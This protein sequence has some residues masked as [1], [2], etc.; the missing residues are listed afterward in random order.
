[1]LESKVIRFD[2]KASPYLFPMQKKTNLSCYLISAYVKL[3][4]Y[5]PAGCNALVF[6]MKVNRGKNV[7][8]LHTKYCL[9]KSVLE[10]PPSVVF[11]FFT[12]VLVEQLGAST[13]YTYLFGNISAS[14]ARVG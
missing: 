9:I 14:D 6:S 3:Q 11:H 5:L 13:N 4:N 12:T 2:I 10:E 7:F 1:M 8:F